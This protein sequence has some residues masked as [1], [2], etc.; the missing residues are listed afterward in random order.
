MAGS[1][2]LECTA[3]AE[4]AAMQKPGEKAT[5][6]FDTIMAGNSQMSLQ[7]MDLAK[8]QNIGLHGVDLYDSRSDRT[9]PNQKNADRQT[10]ASQ[11]GEHKIGNSIHTQM[12]GFSGTIIAPLDR[13]PVKPVI[14]SQTDGSTD[15]SDTRV[16]PSGVQIK[17]IGRTDG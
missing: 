6:T 14:R 10:S 15:Q 11:T 13:Q 12:P 4:K 1:N 16:G 8:C 5:A 7:A 3:P 17:R 9:Q 2:H